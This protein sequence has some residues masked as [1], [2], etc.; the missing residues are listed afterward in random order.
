MPDG[1]KKKKKRQEKVNKRNKPTVIHEVVV[2][3]EL[4]PEAKA[5]KDEAVS[6]MVNEDY[7]AA[8]ADMGEQA[9][10]ADK[11]EPGG[12]YSPDDNVKEATFPNKPVMPTKDAEF[13]AASIIKNALKKKE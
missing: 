1:K 13:D 4:S 9:G 7:E 6:Q 12:I 8:M 2:P 3:E 10:I 5:A 11:P